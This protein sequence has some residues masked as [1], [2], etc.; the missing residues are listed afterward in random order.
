MGETTKER[1]IQLCGIAAISYGPGGASAEEWSPTEFCQILFPAMVHRGPHAFGYMYYDGENVVWEKFE[2]RSDNA[3]V[4]KGIEIPDDIVWLV[5]HV[6]FATTGDPQH[7]ENN[8]PVRHGNI[9]GV[10]NGTVANY[11]T[12]LKDHPRW[13]DEDG[14]VS[15]VD[16][17]AIFA[18]VAASG[19][20]AGLRELIF[21]GVAVYCNLD[22]ATWTLHVARSRKRPILFTSTPTGAK[23]W[24]SESN[25]IDATGIEHDNFV[26]MG[27]NKLWRVREGKIVERVTWR[28]PP[29]V[30][31]VSDKRRGFLQ[32]LQLDRERGMP[33]DLDITPAKRRPRA[34]TPRSERNYHGRSSEVT[35]HKMRNGDR[36]GDKYYY[37]GELLTEKDFREVVQ[38]EAS[39]R[40]DANRDK[41]E[42]G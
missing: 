16:S 41:R 15:E 6:R 8:H 22:S 39:L 33:E 3:K 5:L 1:V 35:T 25:I 30:I 12:V 40:E 14:T 21:E 4:V 38:L 26:S 27:E 19:H 37:E 7:M 17:E 9:V 34:N 11:R 32:Q 20:R 13:A 24:A 23:L 31:S 29:P 36:W 10:H 42:G 28:E 18:A 2:G